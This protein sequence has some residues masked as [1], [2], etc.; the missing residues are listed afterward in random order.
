LEENLIRLILWLV[1]IA[2]W[3]VSGLAKKRK[4][5][6]KVASGEAPDADELREY[7]GDDEPEEE[8][9]VSEEDEFR[10]FLRTLTGAGEK[11]PEIN[12]AP[13]G[14]TKAAAK[15]RAAPGPAASPAEEVKPQAAVKAHRPVRPVAMS[16]PFKKY[17]RDW[18]K[19][20]LRS[21]VIYSEIL[22]PPRALRPYRAIK[23]DSFRS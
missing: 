22:G 13:P 8:P 12:P 5:D 4:D 18:D 17:A 7:F 11:S 10:K 16:R 23:R 20:K 2:V 14:E 19:N 6:R 15:P 21:A 1:F 3:V 9:H